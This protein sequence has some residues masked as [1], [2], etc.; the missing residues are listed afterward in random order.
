MAKQYS[1]MHW[2]VYASSMMSEGIKVHNI[3]NHTR[4]REDVVRALK[5]SETKED[6]SEHLRRELFYYYGSK[7]EWEVIITDWPPR[8][9]VEELD[10]LNTERIEAKEMFNRDPHSLCVNLGPAVKVD[11]YTQVR[12]NWDV[13]LDYVWSFKRPPRPRK[14][15]NPN[16]VS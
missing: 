13:F 16:D 8:I 9:E 1:Q 10:R 3:F 7:C 5:K 6:F 12:N 4:F 14:S 15:A 2:F 11:V